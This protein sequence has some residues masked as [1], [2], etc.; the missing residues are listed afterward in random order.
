MCDVCRRC[1]ALRQACTAALAHCKL[2]F[3]W[4]KHATCFS[5]RGQDM[6]FTLDSKA[7]PWLALWCLHPCAVS[8]PSSE[9]RMQAWKVLAIIAGSVHGCCTQQEEAATQIS[10]YV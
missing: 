10:C 5:G 8:F 3:P 6:Q 1:K 2:V 4:L 9:V 7:L